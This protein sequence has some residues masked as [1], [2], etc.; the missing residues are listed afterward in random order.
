MNK[1]VVTLYL[2]ITFG[3]CFF[4]NAQK[5]KTYFDSRDSTEY[6]IVKIGNTWWFAQNMSFDMPQSSW[7]YSNDPEN[8]ALYGRLYTWTAAKEVCPVGWHLPSKEEWNT[9]IEN[10]GGK[11]V[12]GSRMKTNI[13]WNCSAHQTEKSSGFNALPNGY[14]LS[15]QLFELI[16]TNAYW[17]SSTEY[18]ETEIWVFGLDCAF[19][20]IYKFDY[21]YNAGFGVRCIE[22]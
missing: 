17:W 19:N 13:G 2:F 16:G 11:A 5:T 22:D 3:F 20:G 7:C 6:E 1:I 15:D 18:D 9:L 8:C 4:S 12:A 10:L 21:N 14:R